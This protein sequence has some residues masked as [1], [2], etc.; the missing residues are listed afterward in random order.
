VSAG[1]ISCDIFSGA[2]RR[3]GFAGEIGQKALIRP[4]LS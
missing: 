1:A 3:V 4:G 2:F